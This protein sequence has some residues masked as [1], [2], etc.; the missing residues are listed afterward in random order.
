MNGGATV[1]DGMMH[2][3]MKGGWRRGGSGWWSNK[4]SGGES[5]EENGG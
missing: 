4:W 3:M 2:T 5:V 1:M